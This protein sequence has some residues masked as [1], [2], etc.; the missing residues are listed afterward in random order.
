MIY[1][2][3]F[4]ENLIDG[5]GHT[6]A[7]VGPREASCTPLQISILSFFAAKCV[8]RARLVRSG[9][10]V[11][12]PPRV[13]TGYHSNLWLQALHV[14]MFLYLL[15]MGQYALWRT[16]RRAV[17]QTHCFLG[18]SKVKSTTDRADVIIIHYILRDGGS[19]DP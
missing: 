16:K 19:L 17:C 14:Q 8:I 11:S 12:I 15:C 3:A 2:F 13:P 4:H 6:P 18:L 10:I 5:F 7:S 1:D 9:L